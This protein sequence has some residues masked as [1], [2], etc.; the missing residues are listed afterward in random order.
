MTFLLT[1]YPHTSIKYAYIDTY[2]L[3]YRFKDGVNWL[4]SLIRSSS[5]CERYLPRILQRAQKK[6]VKYVIDASSLDK[7]PLHNL[8]SALAMFSYR[9]KHWYLRRWFY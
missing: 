6:H 3:L 4:T 1:L 2:I 7:N 5:F 9:E 8:E